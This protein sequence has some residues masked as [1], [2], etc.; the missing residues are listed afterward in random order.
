MKKTALII[1]AIILLS[2]WGCVKKEKAAIKI[3]K[4]E[5]SAKEFDSAFKSSRF[6]YAKEA[7]RKE[8]LDT[9]ISRKLMLKEA[10]NLGLDKNPVFLQDIQFFWEQ[11]LLKLLIS[12]KIKEF[13]KTIEI[14]D[15]MIRD[16]Y[17]AHKKENFSDKQLKDVYSQIKIA[18]FKDKAG[19]AITD[20]A[21]SLKSKTKIEA[22]YKLLGLEPNK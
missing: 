15:Q 9:F 3:G 16:Y 21:N 8:F 6:F 13:S 4:I 14:K 12:Q 1:S 2:V 10:E 19:T 22:D 7:K 20:W 11:S 17:E 5:V 18:I